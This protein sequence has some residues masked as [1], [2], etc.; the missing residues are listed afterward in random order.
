MNT[1]A[2]AFEDFILSRE[3]MLCSPATIDFYR[4][5]LTPFLE[6][7][8]GNELSNRHVRAFLA[9]VAQRGVSSSTVHAHT[10]G[11]VHAGTYEH[12]HAAANSRI[13]IT[14]LGVPGPERSGVSATTH[15]QVHVWVPWWLCQSSD[16]VQIAKRVPREAA[17]G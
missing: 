2:V 14:A 7:T 12:A 6:F 1:S 11:D 16:L 17:M 3:A 15:H 9:S 5:M 4:R 13:P 8:N 10:H